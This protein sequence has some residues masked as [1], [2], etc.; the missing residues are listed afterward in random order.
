MYFFKGWA[1]HGSPSVP[2]YPASHGCVRISNADADWLFPCAE[3]PRWSFTTLPAKAPELT[4][5]RPTL[6]QEIDLAVLEVTWGRQLATQQHPWRP[7]VGNRDPSLIPGR[8][9]GK[10][11]EL[12]AVW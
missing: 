5:R 10:Q 6:L 9:E 8:S 7:K 3:R 4:K 12:V 2:A 11:A 1:I